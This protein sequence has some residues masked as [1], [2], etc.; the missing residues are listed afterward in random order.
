M[1]HPPCISQHTAAPAGRPVRRELCGLPL[2]P[3][4]DPPGQ[5]PAPGLLP[6]PFRFGG[7]GK[8]PTCLSPGGFAQPHRSNSRFRVANVEALNQPHPEGLIP[9]AAG[10]PPVPAP[11]A[12]ERRATCPGTGGQV[13]SRGVNSLL[14]QPR[15]SSRPH[16]AHLSHDALL[17]AA[18]TSGLSSP[19]W[20]GVTAPASP[21]GC[22]L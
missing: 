8:A 9:P 18:L 6:N 17:H 15:L 2:C 12:S 14:S 10:P 3:P 13:G 21:R 7:S 5:R 4:P 20:L 1:Y 22:V 11:A 19:T 16:T